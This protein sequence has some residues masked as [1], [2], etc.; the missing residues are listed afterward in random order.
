MTVISY[1][2]N[3]SCIKSDSC[4]KIAYNILEFCIT[5]K[6]W[7]SAAHIPVVSNRE[8]DKQSSFLDDVTKEVIKEL[9]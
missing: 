6:L 2:N 9:L 4:S 1:M 5:E 8:A 3:I 7:I